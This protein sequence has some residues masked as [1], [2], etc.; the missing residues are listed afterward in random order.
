M[1]TERVG[2]DAA[3]LAR[4]WR[5]SY[6]VAC[7]LVK[8]EL[9]LQTAFGVAARGVRWPGLFVISGYRSRP[10]ESELNPGNTA[11]ASL[12]LRCPSL[13][14]DVRVGNLPASSTPRE[15]F[16]A[17]GTVWKATTGGRW[18]GD[19]EPPDVNHLDLPGA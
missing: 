14:V 1:K 12:H 7:G 8:T 18:G 5:V 3:G 17:V 10:V 16:A 13:A 15:L 11:L 6:A 9:A 19:F 4:R 2:L